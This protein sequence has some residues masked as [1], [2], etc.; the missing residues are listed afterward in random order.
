MYVT[1]EHNFERPRSKPPEKSNIKYSQYTNTTGT[2]AN[3]REKATGS[4]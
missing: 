2:R 3:T 4:S 1:Q